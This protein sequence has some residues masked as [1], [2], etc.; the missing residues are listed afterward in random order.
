MTAMEIMEETTEITDTIIIIIL[1]MA[2][3]VHARKEDEST[4]G[5]AGSLQTTVETH[6]ATLATVQNQ[7]NEVVDKFQIMNG[8]IA[9]ESKK[10]K[11]RERDI[12]RDLDT[13][14]NLGGRLHVQSKKKN[15]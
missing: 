13:R 3:S 9:R 12:P 4:A 2:F 11:D 7:V 1:L 5:Y 15:T 10:N 6:S 14:E 8:D